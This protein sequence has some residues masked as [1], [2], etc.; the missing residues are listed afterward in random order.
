MHLA[1]VDHGRTTGG[2]DHARKYSRRTSTSSAN[3]RSIEVNDL[4]GR[5]REVRDV[6]GN[7]EREEEGVEL[8]QLYTAVFPAERYGRNARA[9]QEIRKRQ[10]RYGN[11]SS[12]RAKRDGNTLFLRDLL[13]YI[14]GS[15]V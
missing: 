10:K 12:A 4:E 15:Y 3:R 13:P 8:S 6:G 5:E 11:A 1:N 9:L 2:G 7:G 14:K